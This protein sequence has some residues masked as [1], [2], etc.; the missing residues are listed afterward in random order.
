MRTR[1]FISL[2]RVYPISRWYCNTEAR[3]VQD[4]RFGRPSYLFVA[5][6]SETLERR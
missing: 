4:T 1:L 3:E 5:A 2:R 6:S